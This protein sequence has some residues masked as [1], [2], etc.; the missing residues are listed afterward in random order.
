MI[1]ANLKDTVVHYA[2]RSH[3]VLVSNS[4]FFRHALSPQNSL[5]N[6]SNDDEKPMLASARR[7]TKEG[8]WK[9]ISQPKKNKKLHLYA[10]AGTDGNTCRE[11][12]ATV[13]S[14]IYIHQE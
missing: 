8:L 14:A 6:L 13:G 7:S 3:D 10:L 9:H 4:T 11:S 2:K 5:L 12:R 1:P